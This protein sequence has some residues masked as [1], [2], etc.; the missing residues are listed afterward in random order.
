MKENIKVIIDI[1]E[2]QRYINTF[3]EQCVNSQ[4]IYYRLMNIKI[5]DKIGLLSFCLL[6]S[7]KTRK[8]QINIATTIF[9]NKNS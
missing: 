3:K 1:D 4:M 8:K 6:I 5:Y 7:N 2:K 9:F